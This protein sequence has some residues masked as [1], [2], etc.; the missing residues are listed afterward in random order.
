MILDFGV[1]TKDET[2]SKILKTNYIHIIKLLLNY[3]K[4]KDKNI[5]TDKHFLTQIFENFIGSPI[6]PNIFFDYG[7]KIKN[8]K[9]FEGRD[10]TD[11]KFRIRQIDSN[12]A[13]ENINQDVYNFC[14]KYDIPIKSKSFS[15]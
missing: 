11:A 15:V 14:M 3:L 8:F 7:Y 13:F 1:E 10:L 4:N 6:D 2:I 9:M 12:K 5:I